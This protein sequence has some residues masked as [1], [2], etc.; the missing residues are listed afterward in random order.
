LK[1]PRKNGLRLRGDSAATRQF[2]RFF[3]NC[4]LHIAGT[5]CVLA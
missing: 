4:I 2:V 3:R 5:F 1:S